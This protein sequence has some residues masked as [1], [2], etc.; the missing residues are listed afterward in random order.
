MLTVTVSLGEVSCDIG[1]DSD[2]YSGEVMADMCSRASLTV[3]TM[4][5]VLSPD[6]AT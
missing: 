5:D 3:L 6:K 4:L 2:H 1:F